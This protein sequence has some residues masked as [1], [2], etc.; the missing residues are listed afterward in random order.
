MT[1]TSP[2]RIS[3]LAVACKPAVFDWSIVTLFDAAGSSGFEPFDKAGT[4]VLH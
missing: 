4:K 3:S 2:G 1:N